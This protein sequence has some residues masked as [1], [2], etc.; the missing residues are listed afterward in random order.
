M[1]AMYPSSLAIKRRSSQPLTLLTKPTTTTLGLSTSWLKPGLSPMTRTRFGLIPKEFS[2]HWF[3]TLQSTVR[4]ARLPHQAPP[5]ELSAA[6]ILHE[7]HKTFQH[8]WAI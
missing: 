6:S 5:D 4:R 8:D 1:S 3:D 7:G 2:P